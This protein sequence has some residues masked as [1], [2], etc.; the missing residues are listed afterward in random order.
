M[1]VSRWIRD[2]GYQWCETQRGLQQGY[3]MDSIGI[4]D[5]I[6]YYLKFDRKC[7]VRFFYVFCVFLYVNKEM[8]FWDFTR[9]SG[10]FR[11]KQVA[12]IP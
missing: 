1:D 9:T 7:F 4:M 8:N 10:P 2:Q 5:A 6:G 11:Y 12:T 3:N